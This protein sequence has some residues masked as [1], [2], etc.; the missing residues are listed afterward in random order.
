MR[1]RFRVALGEFVRAP[2]WEAPS[3][4]L[5]SRRGSEEQQKCETYAHFRRVN[6]L[7]RF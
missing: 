3:P 7:R 6:V 4:R 2:V 5:L 1:A